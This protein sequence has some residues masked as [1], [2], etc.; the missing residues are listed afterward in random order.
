MGIEST[1]QQI[2]KLYGD[3]RS[4]MKPWYYHLPGAHTLATIGVT[5]Y[6]AFNGGNEFANHYGQLQVWGGNLGLLFASNGIGQQL[7]KLRE[8]RQVDLAA[9]IAFLEGRTVDNNDPKQLASEASRAT[10]VLHLAH[11]ILPGVLDT[12]MFDLYYLISRRFWNKNE[13]IYQEL[14]ERHL[15]FFVETGGRVDPNLRVAQEITRDA[16]IVRREELR[17]VSINPLSSTRKRV[18]GT[19]VSGRINEILSGLPPFA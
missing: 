19:Y 6:S 17:K 14:A 11:D 4:L 9:N 10:R 15:K 16:L 8:K 13:N 12:G 1:E 3:F 5:A 18:Y 7:E 2:V